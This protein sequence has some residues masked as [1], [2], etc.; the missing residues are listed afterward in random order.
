MIGIQIVVIAVMKLTVMIKMWRHV[1][2]P[3]SRA[4]TIPAFPSHASVT[5]DKT[6]HMGRM[7][8][9]VIVL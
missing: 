1:P 6:A 9:I 4:L 3:T 8:S 7:S 2:H 5:V